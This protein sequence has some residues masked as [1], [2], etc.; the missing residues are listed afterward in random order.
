MKIIIETTND[1]FVQ[2]PEILDEVSTDVLVEKLISREYNF[3]DSVCDDDILEEVEYRDLEHTIVDSYERNRETD[4][5]ALVAE[6]IV[7]IIELI[8]DVRLGSSDWTIV[9]RL[10]RLQWKIGVE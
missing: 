4:S 10:R 8:G 9:D 1:F 6:D 2:N 5:D 7:R 3:L